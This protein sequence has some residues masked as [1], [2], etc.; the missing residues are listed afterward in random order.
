M[1]VC[2][3]LSHKLY[4]QCVRTF[5]RITYVLSLGYN[6][7][8]RLFLIITIYFIYFTSL[9]WIRTKLVLCLIQSS[10]F[11]FHFMNWDKNTN[12]SGE[13]LIFVQLFFLIYVLGYFYHNCLEMVHLFSIL[14]WTINRRLAFV[15]N[16][17]IKVIWKILLYGISL[18]IK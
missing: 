4:K 5:I 18:M 14:K 16:W 15:F 2:Y 12:L 17:N 8:R 6:A 11:H 1:F 13:N 9:M 7:A 10:I 3:L